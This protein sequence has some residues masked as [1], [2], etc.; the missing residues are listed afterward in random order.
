MSYWNTVVRWS[1]TGASQTLNTVAA[2]SGLFDRSF[3]DVSLLAGMLIDKF[4]YHLPLHRQHQRMAL[5]GITLSR[6]TLTR[7]VQQAIELLRPVSEALLQSVLQSRVL[8]MDETPAR[9]GRKEKGRMHKAWF[10]PVY[11]EQNEVVFTFS[12]T[13]A[14]R[15]IEPLLKDFEGVLLTDGYGVYDSYCKKHPAITQAQ[16]WVHCRRY[17]TRAEEYEPRAVAQALEIIGQLYCIE[18]TVR[19]RQ[20]AEDEKKRYR[21]QHSTPLVN[22]FFEWCRKEQHRPELVKSNPL[23]KALTYAVNHQQQMRVFLDDPQV[24]MDTNHLE[25]LLRCIPMGR[26]SMAVLLDGNRR[27]ARCYYPEPAGELPV[28]GY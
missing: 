21:Q 11:G 27:R 9:V 17:F 25:R 23:S 8:A 3:A 28:A 22:Q 6:A 12:M 20:L 15:H 7:L 2:P 10:W 5:N 19:E 18:K 26:K 16:C 4:V 13:R 14:T 24:P 1:N